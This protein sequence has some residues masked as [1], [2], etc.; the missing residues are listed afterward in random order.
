[1][2]VAFVAHYTSMYG[3]NRS[4]LDLIDGLRPFGVDPF[5]VCPANG[6]L[7][8]ELQNRKVPYV[9]IPFQSWT[10][11]ATISSTLKAPLRLVL[12]M[13]MLPR[14]VR[15]IKDWGTDI[16]YTNSSVT[17]VGQWAAIIS[18]RP[19]VWHIREFGW[20]DY[21][22]KYDWGQTFFR[23]W[24]NK[25]D[26]VIA[27]S[28][29]IKKDVCQGI[30]SNVYTIY[31]GV[32]SR[33]KCI[34]LGRQ[35]FSRATSTKYIFVILG[36][37]NPNKGQED[38]IRGLAVLCKDFPSIHLHIV[39]TGQAHY[40]T[41][42]KQ[43]C[44]ELGVEDRVEFKG[45][46][47][48]PFAALLEADAFLMC[49]RH[50]AM[51]RVTAEAMAAARPV[52]GYNNGGTPELIENEVTGLLYEGGHKELAQCMARFAERREWAAELGVNGWN[53]AQKEFIIEVYAKRI[54]EVLKDVRNRMRT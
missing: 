21:Q 35:G 20:L 22:L 38:A 18:R 19:H 7:C 49:S 28:E 34:S 16:V 3:A 26:A 40:I 29:A 2:R 13:A 14:L 41:Q 53:K 54:Y 12:N 15:Q 30:R 10:K 33:D 46:I 23:Y 36:L 51:G 50:E 37:I 9:V 31:N 6:D 48:N 42:L 43:L 24:L 5:V 8:Q 32:V 4:L 47:S 44:R 17:P 45:Y 25:A 27:I 1:M 52:I 11:K 39:G